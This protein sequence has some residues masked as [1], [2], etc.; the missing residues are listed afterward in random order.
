MRASLSSS[1]SIENPR[2]KSSRTSASGGSSP[3]IDPGQRWGISQARAARYA[4]LQ[5]VGWVRAGPGERGFPEVPPG[6]VPRV[7]G[8]ERLGEGLE[9]V[10]AFE[11]VGGEQ[12]RFLRQALGLL[13]HESQTGILGGSQEP[14]VRRCPEHRVGVFT[15]LPCGGDAGGEVVREQ[16]GELTRPRP[17]RLLDPA[18]DARVRGRALA[19]REARVG[20]V[21][22]EDVLEDVLLLAGDRRA[23]PAE[24]ELAIRKDRER[25][26]EV[27]RLA[28]QERP[29]RTG[30]EHATD[31]RRPLEDP[32]R[33]GVEEIDPRRE[34]ALHRVRDV[35][36]SMPRVAR[37]RSPVRTMLP[38]SI[39]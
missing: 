28:V 26:V 23:E 30:P 31:H 32:L 4:T 13:D 38:S 5:A 22:R 34:D 16:L 11:I 24:H 27:G 8:E 15:R 20:D 33:R 36:S 1:G 35:T 2:S 37:H 18:G 29:D 21:A 3:G 10:G 9:G 12:E 7:V 19:A 14:S 39:R 17:H 6:R 25:G